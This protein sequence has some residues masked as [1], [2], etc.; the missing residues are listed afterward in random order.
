MIGIFNTIFKYKEKA[1]PD[2]LGLYPERVHVDAMPE[3]RYLWTSRFLVIVACFSICFNIMLASSIYVM[4]PQRG[5]MPQMFYIDHYFSQIERA[6]PIEID[7]PAGNLINEEHITNYIMMRYLITNDYDELLRRWGPGSY[8]YWYSS[9][10][11]YDDFQRYDARFNML[12]FRKRNM[13]RDVEI[14]WIRPLSKGLWQ[15]QFRTLDYTIGNPEPSVNIWRAIMRI[16]FVN[17]MN[18]TD[19][20][21]LK[22]PFGFMVTNYSLSYLGQPTGSEHYL[23]TAKRITR[24]LFFR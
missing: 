18:R 8:I 10:Y 7:Y 4:L 15:T 2:K 17:F 1:S 11:I 16:Q 20:D 13:M 6:Q 24:E 12:Q 19:E 22:N 9:P 23:N 21:A 14:D 3:R 5:A